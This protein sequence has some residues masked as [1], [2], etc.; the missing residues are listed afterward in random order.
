MSGD[1]VNAGGELGTIRH[2]YIIIRSTYKLEDIYMHLD[3]KTQLP[4]NR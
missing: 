1:D 4:W 3:K 2:P